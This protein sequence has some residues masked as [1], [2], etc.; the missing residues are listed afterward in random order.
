MAAFRESHKV[1]WRTVSGNI[2][3]VVRRRKVIGNRL[4]SAAA[5]RKFSWH[6]RRQAY[7]GIQEMADQTHNSQHAF[8]RGLGTLPAQK[9]SI[10]TNIE[11]DAS[12]NFFPGILQTVRDFI[13]WAEHS[14]NEAFCD[15][16]SKVW[17]NK[18]P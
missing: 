11:C 18:N 12:L 16:F 4:G 2:L 14:G 6:F 17:I 3:A 9:G 1:P 5:E 15:Q 13:W 8:Q 10:E 7:D